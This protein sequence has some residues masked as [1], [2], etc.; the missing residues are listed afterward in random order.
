MS[1]KPNF[2]KKLSF[3]IYVKKKMKKLM[4]RQKNVLKKIFVKK[5]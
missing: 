2:Y 4:I 1:K 3:Y 5:V